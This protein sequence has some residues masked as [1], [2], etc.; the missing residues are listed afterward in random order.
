MNKKII[1][2]FKF[3]LAALI[4]GFVF[5]QI[6][7]L[8]VANNITP[9]KADAILILGHALDSNSEPDEFLEERLIKGLEVYE[10][11]LSNLIIVSGKQ[12]PTDDKPVAEAMK[13]W[14]MD[15]GIKSENIIVEDNAGNTYENFKFSKQ[16][17]NDIDSIIVVTN[18]FHMYR[19]LLIG[20][21]F[22]SEVSGAPAHL[23]WSSRKLINY[24]KEPFS[25]IKYYLFL[26]G[27]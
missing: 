24:I 12:G 3:L 21:E 20:K 26:K 8:Y 1:M 4:F 11:G 7:I 13:I 2:T 19:S 15:R 27:N 5:C 6:Q 9:E 22:Y 16:L 23:S 17:N 10:K 18:D 14:L 25:I